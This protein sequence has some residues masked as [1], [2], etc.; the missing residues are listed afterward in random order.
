MAGWPLPVIYLLPLPS[1]YRVL[2]YFGSVMWIGSLLTG[3]FGSGTGS[4]GLWD[5]I[6]RSRAGTTGF[7]IAWLRNRIV[8][9]TSRI[10]RSAGTGLFGLGA[11]PTVLSGES[12][13]IYRSPSR[14][15]EKLMKIVNCIVKS[16]Y[17]FKLRMV[18]GARYTSAY[19][20]WRK[21]YKYANARTS[22]CMQKGGLCDGI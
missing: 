4:S 17:D 2:F 8:R 22:H 19:D 6:V 7:G 16:Y 11:G 14:L 13:C 3:S 5:R 12:A 9:L 15:L 21:K 20:I 10:A 18:R 1:P